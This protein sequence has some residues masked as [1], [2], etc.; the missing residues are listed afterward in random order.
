ML[1]SGSSRKP[2]QEQSNKHLIAREI[3][4]FFIT[5]YNSIYYLPLI[6]AE[7]HFMPNPVI[8]LVTL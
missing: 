2:A 4:A 3:A 5:G 7:F 8:A 1:S 6:A